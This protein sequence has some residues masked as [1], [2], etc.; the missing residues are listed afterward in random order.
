MQ[1][2]QIV[3]RAAVDFQLEFISR[4]N[5]GGR[6][7]RGELNGAADQTLQL[8]GNVAADHHGDVLVGIQP[9]LLQTGAAPARCCEPPRVVV[10]K[11]LPLSSLERFHFRF[12]D[13]PEKIFLQ[14]LGYDFGRQI[15]ALHG[16]NDRADVVDRV[17]IAAQQRGHADIAPDLHDVGLQILLGEKSRAPGRCRDRRKR[18][19]GWDR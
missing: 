19:C 6:R 9:G 3:E 17:G 2:G 13:Q 7:Q 18:C 15:A 11:T 8:G 14:T 16:A 12:G 5:D 1:I 10:P 4:Q